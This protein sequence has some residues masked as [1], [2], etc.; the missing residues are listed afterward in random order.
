MPRKRRHSCVGRSSSD[1]QRMQRLR[2]HITINHDE[3]TVC[4]SSNGV[5]NWLDA[6]FSYDP[7]KSYSTSKDV[8]IG[9]M[10]KICNFCNAKK[11]TDESPG[12]CCTG[13][14]I[15]L[16]ALENPPIF[17]HQLLT[18]KSTRANGFRN[19]LWKYNAAF[20]MTSFGA[21]KDLT[22][23]GF[24]TTYKIQGQCY[25]KIGA[26]LPSSGEQSKYA[27]VFFMGG[28][29]QEADQRCLLNPGVDH[30]I[31]L[32][33]QQMLH[34]THPY[35]RSLKFA[36]E[37]M[38]SDTINYKLVIHADKKP[39]GEHERR[40]NTPVAN[41]VAVVMIGEHY[42]N[43]DIVLKQRDQQL[44]RICETHRSY[45][46]LQYPLLFA[47]G[48]DGYHF[49]VSQVHPVTGN[50]TNKKISCQDFYA[51]RFMVRS[52]SFNHL[53]LF[54]QVTSQLFVDMYAK[55]ESERLLYIRLH[56]KQLRA[57]QY[58]HLRDALNADGHAKS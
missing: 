16:P 25:H 40:F 5:V 27:Q 56:Q 54:K 2:G 45:D 53:L 18:E 47:R 29:E 7:I 19:K 39:S 30:E 44:M 20:M 11:W 37:F 52:D 41:E 36:K 9:Q 23:R 58:V 32:G 4:D 34:D 8:T 50:N 42:G 12:M 17:L 21:D 33:L 49:N 3:N 48:E 43:R 6:A 51:Y 28:S 26:L 38:E 10:N 15:K 22:E 1:A 14:K 55:M 57:D 31:I 46:C 24:C 13:G 35:V